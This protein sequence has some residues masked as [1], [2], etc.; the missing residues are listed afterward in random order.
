MVILLAAPTYSTVACATD[1]KT[2]VL[3]VQGWWLYANLHLQRQFIVFKNHSQKRLYFL[4]VI[5]MVFTVC[6]GKDLIQKSRLYLWRFLK[7]ALNNMQLLQHRTWIRHVNYTCICLTQVTSQA[8]TNNL[9]E[10]LSW[11][12]WGKFNSDEFNRTIM[13]ILKSFYQAKRLFSA[14]LS[15]TWRKVELK[16]NLSEG[17]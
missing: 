17:I 4:T 11:L 8:W 14:N 2:C 6:H 7:P 10:M 12:K 9:T 1:F 3:P 13:I 5:N 15:H 16:L